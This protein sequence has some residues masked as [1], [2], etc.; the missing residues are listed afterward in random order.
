[1]RKALA[2]L[3]ASVMGAAVIVAAGPVSPTSAGTHAGPVG[4][5]AYTSWGIY[6]M[7]PDGSDTL[8]LGAPGAQW[9]SWSPDGTKIAYEFQAAGEQTLSIW[10][11][12]ADGSNP[13]RVFGGGSAFNGGGYAEGPSWSPDG[14][15]IVFSWRPYYQ[16]FPGFYDL[17]SPEIYAVAPDGTG[18]RQI[19]NDGGYNQEPEFS[20]DG[21]TIAFTSTRN[22]GPRVQDI[23]YDIYTV[24]AD[25]SGPATQLT[26]ASGWEQQPSWSPDGSALT[27]S[28]WPEANTTSQVW[29][30]DSDGTDQRAVSE[31][32]PYGWMPTFSPDGASIVYA[33]SVIGS[34]WNIETIPVTGG[35]ATTLTT[36]EGTEW[37]PNWGVDSTAPEITC[38]TAP[39]FTKGASGAQVTATVADNPG[40]T[41]VDDTTLSAPV[42]TGTI[43]DFTV[44]FNASDRAGNDADPVSCAYS[45]V[46]PLLT[47]IIAPP[48]DPLPTINSAKAGR[49]V[50]LKF[51]VLDSAGAPVTGATDVQVKTTNLSCNAGTAPDAI[52]EYVANSGLRELG[53]GW[54]QWNWASPK[55]YAGTCRSLSVI[56]SGTTVVTANFTFVR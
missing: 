2:L 20:P 18:L 9:P 3:T 1:M 33:Q 34:N 42:G 5:I 31:T 38:D 40:G 43:G 10:V 49:V 30:M 37:M 44:E 7:N 15:E 35:T 46:A 47:G 50:P 53:D 26:S 28:Y 39:T 41:G 51:R 17:R 48:V 45:V 14:T 32:W 27:Y 52:E 55:S 6:T 8:Y 19:T 54:Y 36:G 11:M 22:P 29:I 25:G 24:P 23:N 56:V 4:R 21:E 12:D 16:R 13:T